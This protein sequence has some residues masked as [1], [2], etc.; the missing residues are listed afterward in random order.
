M[1][2]LKFGQ[3]GASVINNN[4][5]NNIIINYIKNKFRSFE[6]VN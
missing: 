4:Y 5:D 6:K 3:V 1:L 2:A